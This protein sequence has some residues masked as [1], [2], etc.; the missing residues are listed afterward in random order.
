MFKRSQEKKNTLNYMFKITKVEY[1]PAH[2]TDLAVGTL[3]ACSDN[4]VNFHRWVEA[5]AMV[6]MPTTGTEQ[7]FMYISYYVTH[8]TQGLF[9]SCK[10]KV[11]N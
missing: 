3:P 4:R 2:L 1:L 9:S 10:D 6:M 5:V 11:C 8:H 7:L